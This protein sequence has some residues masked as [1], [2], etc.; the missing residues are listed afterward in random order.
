MKF[1]LF[2]KDSN[3]IENLAR[4]IIRCITVKKLM[5]NTSYAFDVFLDCIQ[6]AHTSDS[7]YKPIGN[8]FTTHTATMWDDVTDLENNILL[9]RIYRME[10]LIE[11]INSAFEECEIQRKI[12][13]NERI[14]NQNE[15]RKGYTPN[16]SQRAKIER[17]FQNDFEIYENA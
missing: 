17:I 9:K 15:G 7:I 13:C 10:N 3:L 4:K 6:E 11:G 16:T 1:Y 2:W 14:F 5:L 8:H 12:C